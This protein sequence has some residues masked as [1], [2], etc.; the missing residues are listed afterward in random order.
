M[1]SAATLTAASL[2][3]LFAFACDAN[4]PQ[5]TTG[6]SAA[7]EAPAASE[8]PAESEAPRLAQ[9]WTTT[10]STDCGDVKYGLGADHCPVDREANLRRIVEP[11]GRRQSR[12]GREETNGWERPLA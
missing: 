10:P 8:A 9:V 11:A 4:P 7:A 5:P 12:R 3:T 1:T 2:L 6:A